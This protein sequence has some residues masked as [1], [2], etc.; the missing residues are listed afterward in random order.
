MKVPDWRACPAGN[1]GGKP[2][3]NEYSAL[4]TLAGCTVTD[5]PVGS[6]IAS[7]FSGRKKKNEEFTS[8]WGNN[9]IELAACS[10]RGLLWQKV[11]AR[12]VS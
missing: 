9:H 3:F 4:N 8:F 2:E 5:R 12:W 7:S 11:R 10:T 6:E 1:P